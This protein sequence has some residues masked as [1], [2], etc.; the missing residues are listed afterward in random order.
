MYLGPLLLPELCEE[1]TKI[2]YFELTL[3][4]VGHK[5]LRKI[6]SISHWLFQNKPRNMHPKKL[7]KKKEKTLDIWESIVDPWYCLFLNSYFSLLWV[8]L[9][10]LEMKILLPCGYWRP[11][12]HICDCTTEFFMIKFLL[13]ILL[14]LLLLLS[15]FSRVRLCATP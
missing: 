5:N 15:R 13:Y 1:I 4:L 9:V 14:L 8:T 6:F 10:F 2:S 7:K 12:G 3:F 11:W